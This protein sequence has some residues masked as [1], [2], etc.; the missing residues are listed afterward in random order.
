MH[1]LYCIVKLGLHAQLDMS[2]FCC[3]LFFVL[4]SIKSKTQIRGEVLALGCLKIWDF[5]LSDDLNAFSDLM[6]SKNPFGCDDFSEFE[7]SA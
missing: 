1:G 6:L 3:H 5:H 2:R 4:Q 7:K